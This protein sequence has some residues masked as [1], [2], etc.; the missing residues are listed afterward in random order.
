MSSLTSLFIAPARVIHCFLH[1]LARLFLS[2]V[3]LLSLS[4]SLSLTHSLAAFGVDKRDGW[5][6]QW[7]GERE[8]EREREK[9]HMHNECTS[10][11]HHTIHHTVTT[12]ITNFSHASS[13]YCFFFRRTRERERERERERKRESIQS[14]AHQCHTPT[15]KRQK[16]G[17]QNAG[18]FIN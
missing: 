6:T 13:F 9:C 4:L 7:T 3:I 2:L 17:C 16:G 10:S 11:H 18:K 15:H 14:L 1:P 12:V 8:R 5:M